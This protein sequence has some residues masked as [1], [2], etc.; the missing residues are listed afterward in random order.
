M[1]LIFSDFDGTLTLHESLSPV[2]FDVL[3][4]IQENK[5]EL[6]VVSGRSVS[7]GHFLLTHFPLRYAIMEGGGVILRKKQQLIEHQYCVSRAEIDE[8]SRATDELK[9]K[10]PGAILSADSLGRVT[11]RAL[12]F[13][14]MEPELL[15]QAKDF[16]DQKEIHY[17]QSNVHLNFWKGNISKFQTV[18]AFMK[19]DF[20]KV[21]MDHCLYFGDSLNDQSM[22]QFFPHTVGVSNIDECIDQMEHQPKIILEGPHNRGP[23]GVLRYLQS[24]FNEGKE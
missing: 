2:F 16:L 15:G 10:L 17:S 13:R 1:S 5:A 14:Y 4:C 7:W 22:F 20:P 23:E 6:V 21:A 8:L 24:F 9:K 19:S 12:E 3:Q 18:E 11:D